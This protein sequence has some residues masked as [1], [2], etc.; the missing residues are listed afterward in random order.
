VQSRGRRVTLSAHSGGIALV[1][2]YLVGG[3]LTFNTCHFLESARAFTGSALVPDF[4]EGDTA[5]RTA[6]ASLLVKTDCLQRYE[7]STWPDCTSRN[8]ARYLMHR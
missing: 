3:K 6:K 2:C 5:M 7:L 8:L 1:F 4:L